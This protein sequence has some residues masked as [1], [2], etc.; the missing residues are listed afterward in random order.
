MENT[1]SAL[2]VVDGYMYDVL[3]IAIE[4]SEEG[5]EVEQC[6]N[7]STVHLCI[8]SVWSQYPTAVTLH[9]VAKQAVGSDDRDT[10]RRL[11]AISQY[12]PVRWDAFIPTA[13]GVVLNILI[14]AGVLS[15]GGQ[16]DASLRVSSA[17]TSV[18]IRD[19]SLINAYSI[20]H[21]PLDNVSPV[22]SLYNYVLILGYALEAGRVD[23]V[24]M[25]LSQYSGSQ[26]KDSAIQ[27]LLLTPQYESLISGDYTSMSVDTMRYLISMEYI[28]M[29][30]RLVSIIEDVP[31]EY[32]SGLITSDNISLIFQCDSINMWNM[33]SRDVSLSAVI[34][35]LKYVHGNIRRSILLSLSDGVSGK[36][37]VIAV[38]LLQ[39]A[40]SDEMDEMMSLHYTGDKFHPLRLHVLI[41]SAYRGYVEILDKYMTDKDMYQ[42]YT[43][44]TVYKLASGDLYRFLDY[45]YKDT[46]L[47]H[48][49]SYMYSIINGGNLYAPGYIYEKYLAAAIV[50]GNVRL[51]LQISEQFHISPEIREKA[52]LLTR[53]SHTLNLALYRELMRML[54]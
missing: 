3:N 29:S 43:N 26:Q 17:P 28:Q 1:L 10:I 7:P 45:K 13:S 30:D 23:I 18:Q 22:I 9:E 53:Q 4:A 6:R 16:A 21:I 51:V 42:V 41:I 37:D 50:S 12:I 39:G 24:S 19:V 54:Q 20:R 33:Y 52:R 44:I 15:T 11:S 32:Q 14:N 49:G 5:I 35:L 25:I 34:S 47:S 31:G 38:Q 27:L 48:V 8:D 46:Y 40:T 2:D 36:N